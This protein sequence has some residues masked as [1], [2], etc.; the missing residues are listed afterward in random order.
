M[1]KIE[2]GLIIKAPWARALAEGRKRWELRNRPSDV[3]G[4]VAILEGGSCQAVGIMELVDCIGPLD[5]AALRLAARRGLILPEE[6]H[7]ADQ[8]P[9]YAWVVGRA[10][11]FAH[12][13]RYRHPRGAVVWVKLDDQMSEQI[14]AAV[15]PSPRIA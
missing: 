7:D 14:R 3:R 6:I 15:R 1:G 13:I 10:H 4:P 2:R 8:Q 9:Q 5:P 12:P 11:A